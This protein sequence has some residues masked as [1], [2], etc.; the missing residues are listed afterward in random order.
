MVSSTVAASDRGANGC[1]GDIGHIQFGDSR[2]LCRCGN[3]GC[4]EA[5]AGGY[6]LARA[7][8]RLAVSGDSPVLVEMRAGG[9]ELTSADLQVAVG[10]GDQASIELVRSAGTA[11]GTVLA[12]LVNFYNPNLIVIGGRVAQL[13][14]LLI[15]SIR[16]AVYRR[17]LPLATRDITIA[18]TALGTKAGVV[19]AAA[20][21]LDQL[22]QLGPVRTVR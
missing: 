19:G 21:V 3:L 16:E 1:A 10:R 13:G 9:R 2:A 8:E 15:A 17:S 18:G 20:V 4:L 12:G 11:V 7:A 14:D 22:F 6:A 5:I